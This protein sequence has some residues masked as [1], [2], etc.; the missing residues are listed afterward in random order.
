MNRPLSYEP[1]P[2]WASRLSAP[3][4]KKILLI[5]IDGL[6]GAP[7]PDHQNMTELQA[8]KLPNLDRFL[9][10]KQAATGLICPVGRLGITPGSGAG[11]LGLFGYDP[12]L[13]HVPRGRLESAATEEE[14]MVEG[15]V[16]ARMNFCTL[17]QE[18]K[19]L[20]R[21]AGRIS[22]C[23]RP[24]KLLNDQVKISGAEIKIV[25]TKEHRAVFM[26]KPPINQGWS[27][28]IIDTDPQTTGVP[29][30]E[31]RP[32]KRSVGVQ[33]TAHVINEFV[34]QAVQILKD[35][36]PT[37]GVL[38]RSFT[39]WTHLFLPDD[40]RRL[41]KFNTAYAVK[42]AAIAAYPLY[43]G[44]AKVVGMDVMKGAT[45][46][47]SEIALLQQHQWDYT[48]FFLHYKDPDSRGEDGDFVGKVAALERFDEMFPE[49]CA[50][51][52]DVVALTGDHATPSV[53]AAHSSDPVPL[54]IA[55]GMKQTHDPETHF[56]ETHC[57][58]GWL[59]VMNGPDLMPL[60]LGAAGK[61]KKFDGFA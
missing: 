30:L 53:I 36:A 47:K 9:R 11:H 8:A 13:Y 18:G 22:D 45:N 4:S 61:L 12:F 21:R 57:R 54:A 17:D 1:T 37:N 3:N 23:S 24:A 35:E 49:I 6:G 31:A 38:L 20:D 50:M 7:H 33:K 56:D 32:L 2:V 27:P 10:E 14:E 34:R 5:I 59:G 16:R 58:S 19:I 25:A 28:E 26:L 44:I 15:E 55:G 43:Q 51:Q 46:L 60:L 40:P 39:G 52:F 41:P 48:F 29:P 42:S